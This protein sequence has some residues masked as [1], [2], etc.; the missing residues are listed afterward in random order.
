[1]V[2]IPLITLTTDF[3]VQTHGIAAMK[4]AIFDINPNARVIDLAHGLPDFELTAA[5][6][7]LETVWTMPRG[8]HVCVVDPGVGTKRKALAVKTARGDVLVGPDNGVLVPASG[9]L[10]GITKI[11]EIANPRYFRHPVS[12]TFHGRDVFAPAAA[13]VSKGVPFERLGPPVGAATL[14]KSPYSEA[15]VRNGALEAE[16]ISVN[17]FGSIRFNVTRKA[18]E[19]FGLAPGARVVLDINGRRLRMPFT[20]T[21]GDVEQGEELM[22]F[23]EYGR[24]EAALNRGSFRERHMAKVGQRAAIRLA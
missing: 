6:R 11:V 15:A 1:M 16:V 5:A 4:G 7:T 14:K 2:K 23:D 19:A 3:G 24:V 21:F 10:G 20:R 12:D 9:F 18:G 17:K 13:Y 22:F 8:T